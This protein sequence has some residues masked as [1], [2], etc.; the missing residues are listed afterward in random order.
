MKKKSLLPFMKTGGKSWWFSHR[1]SSKP[2]TIE[3]STFSLTAT[4]LTSLKICCVREFLGTSSV[5]PMIF[6]FYCLGSK[7]YIFDYD[8]NC[9]TMHKCAKVES[10]KFLSKPAILFLA[11]NFL[12]LVTSKTAT[13]ERGCELKSKSATM[14]NISFGFTP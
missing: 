12:C 7:R 13:S 9:T 11:S 6:W 8:L 5:Y 14:N 3:G 1:V 4:A 2:N 10:K